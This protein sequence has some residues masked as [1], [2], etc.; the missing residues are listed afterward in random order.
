[1]V[2]LYLSKTI[3]LID[4]TNKLNKI[5]NHKLSDFDSIIKKYNKI[6]L[7]T[8]TSKTKFIKY[9]DKLKKE[10]FKRYETNW[11]RN[12]DPVDGAIT[13]NIIYKK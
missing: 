10:G 12:N 1:M 5:S 13:A 8:V 4:T 11:I 3:T 9:E 2:T 7:D 6:Q